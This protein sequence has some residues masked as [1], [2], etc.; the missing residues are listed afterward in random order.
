[1]PAPDAFDF[2]SIANESAVPDFDASFDDVDIPAWN[3]AV[4]GESPSQGSTSSSS[5]WEETSKEDPSMEALGMGAGIDMQLQFP[6]VKV[7]AIGDGT[8]IIPAEDEF[9]RAIMEAMQSNPRIV[10]SLSFL[11]YVLPSA[12]ILITFVRVGF[13]S[14]V[15]FGSV[16]WA[17]RIWAVLGRG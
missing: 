11:L 3:E 13:C 12:C 17:R 8:G 5:S 6:T 16:A 14:L 10:S 1:M 7:D 2:S 9:L 4:F 15:R